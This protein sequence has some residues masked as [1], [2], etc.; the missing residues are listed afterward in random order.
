MTLRFAGYAALFDR[1]DRGGDIV[2]QQIL[3]PKTAPQFARKAETVVMDHGSGVLNIMYWR[4]KTVIELVV[5]NWWASNNLFVAKDAGVENY[6]VISVDNLNAED[7]A[8]K[9]DACLAHFRK[10][11]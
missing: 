10:G 5:V 2:R 6:A 11:A 8:K 9:I 1:I 7:I 4:P 3:S